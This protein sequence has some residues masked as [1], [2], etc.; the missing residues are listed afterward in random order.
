[1]IDKV[2]ISDFLDDELKAGRKVELERESKRG[3]AWPLQLY[4]TL[5]IGDQVDI[6]KMR[7]LI[8]ILIF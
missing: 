1:M 3:D 6:V 8:R 5:H 2:L 7:F 4:N